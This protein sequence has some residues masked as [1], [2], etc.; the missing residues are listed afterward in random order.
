VGLDYYISLSAVLWTVC[1][2]LGIVHMDVMDGLKF[3]KC[4]VV[5][6]KRGV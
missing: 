5:M 1:G 6:W 4:L 2:C 3:A